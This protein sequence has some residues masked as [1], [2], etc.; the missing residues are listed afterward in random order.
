MYPNFYYI[1]K[2]WFGIELN[3][4]NLVNS[5][6]FF[7]AV[8]FILANLVM[9]KELKRKFKDGIL[10]KG[11]TLK[12]WEGKPFEINEYITAGIT[13]FILG[14]KFLPV[15]LDFSITKNDPQ[16]YILSLD[17][18]F[19][20]GLLVMVIMLG[21]TFYQDKKQRLNP[22]QERTKLIDP[23]YFMSSLTMAAFVGGILG[24]KLFH[25]LENMSDFWANPMDAI[26]SFSGLTFYGGLI[27]GGGAVLY[28]ARKK[29]IDFFHMLDV[30]AP[31]MMLAYGTGRIGCHVS[32]DGDWGIV[33]TAPKPT[34]LSYMP[35]WFWAYNYPNNVNKV[36][37][38]YVEG[39]KEHIENLS[40]N[41][42][43][44][45]YLIAP[46]FPTPLYEAI[47]CILLFFV[48]WY[49]RKKI[50]YAGVLFGIYLILNGLE[51]FLIEKIRVNNTKDYLG[52][53]LTQAEIISFSLM[54][55][56]VVLIIFGMKKKIPVKQTPETMAQELNS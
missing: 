52:I 37:N 21:F 16:S 3:G 2:D 13:G 12:Y 24:S 28:I 51:R 18:N 31:A 40:C 29:G 44:T 25:I 5:F 46:V 6:G 9:T 19:W 36:C 54:I 42:E 27:V 17:G 23:S 26:M 48:L 41:F 4:L 56:G 33:N 22:P 49:L 43:Q 20:Q 38:P 47:V 45:P 34:W 7:V 53:Q 11:Q 39:T 1:F 35:D 8:S 10:G 32:G 30:G 14:F 50:K 15:M 55:L